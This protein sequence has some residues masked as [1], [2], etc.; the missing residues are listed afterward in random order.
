MTIYRHPR[1]AL[2]LRNGDSSGPA[3]PPF[4]VEWLLRGIGADSRFVTD[5][6]GDLLEERARRKQRDGAVAARWWYLREVLRSAPHVAWNAV[7]YGGVRGRARVAAWLVAVVLVPLVVL[8]AQ[9][10]DGG[11]VARQVARLVV[12]PQGVRDISDGLVVNTVHPVQLS[13]HALD[14]KGHALPSADVSYR[15]ISGDPVSVSPSG[16]VTCSQLGDA[17]LR[18]SIGRVSTPVLVRCRPVRKLLAES[19]LQLVVGDSAR[20]LSFWALSPDSQVVHR[21]TGDIYVDD[22]TVAS[23]AGARIRALTAG[24]TRV[25]MHVGDSQTSTLVSVY[26]PVRTLDGLRPDQRFVAA[27]VR[28]APG[29]TIRWSLPRGHFVLDYDPDFSSQPLPK[30]ALSGW[31]ACAPAVIRTIQPVSCLVGGPGASLRISHPGTRT[32]SITGVIHLERQ[33][34]K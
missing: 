1:A 19:W 26:E 29:E 12:E 4:S 32:S 18:A 8:V 10:M 24:H 30:I 22:S 34:S 3:A 28:L 5:V 17:L 20:S 14:A 15:W 11:S 16:V 23:L 27:P 7:R 25:T 2:L 13:V 31:I 6:L 9:I 33:R 21:L